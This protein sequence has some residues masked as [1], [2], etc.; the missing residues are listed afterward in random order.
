M[1]CIALSC[2]IHVVVP[3][4]IIYVLRVLHVLTR[5]LRLL[6]ANSAL[7]FSCGALG[8]SHVYMYVVAV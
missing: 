7:R 8:A 5:R 4:D 6:H 3:I 2:C 1:R